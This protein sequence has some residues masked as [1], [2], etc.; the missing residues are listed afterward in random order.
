MRIFVFLFA[1]IFLLTGCGQRSE[2]VASAP[3]D[4]SAVV[5]L[6]CI[7]FATTED[8]S[9]FNSTGLV[10]AGA[11]ISAKPAQE[12]KGRMLQDVTNKKVHQHKSDP[13]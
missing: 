4:A 9:V 6:T 10:R 3:N 12:C 2:V 8:Q 1:P 7:E 11:R 13:V 5:V